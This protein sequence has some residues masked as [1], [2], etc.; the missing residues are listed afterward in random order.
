MYG[1]NLSRW[2]SPRLITQFMMMVAKFEGNVN[3][4]S[5][6]VVNRELTNKRN[7]KDHFWEPFRVIKYVPAH[8]VIECNYIFSSFQTDN[9][10]KPCSAISN[11]Y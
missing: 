8:W 7:S 10:V 6:N 3:E 2:Q 5:N 11:A 1:K 4:K 9:G